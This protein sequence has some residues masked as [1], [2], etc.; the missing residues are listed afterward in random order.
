MFVA[1]FASTPPMVSIPKLSQIEVYNKIF[2]SR[3]EQ[4]LFV[5]RDSFGLY[6]GTSTRVACYVSY[7]MRLNSDKS[8][9][10]KFKKTDLLS[11]TEGEIHSK[12][13]TEGKYLERYIIT[14][15]LY[16]EYYTERCPSR[17]V[18]PT[19]PEL[20]PPDKLLLSRQKLLLFVTE[21]PRPRGGQGARNLISRTSYLCRSG[22]LQEELRW[23]ALKSPASVL[24]RA[25]TRRGVTG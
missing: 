4:Y 19:F 25:A 17:L 14:K 6:P 18:R 8:D 24:R 5:L 22:R 15:N 16:L 13:Y 21:P 12:I 10:E 9:P 7:G 3:V 23:R 11:A 20:Y 2:D 1:H